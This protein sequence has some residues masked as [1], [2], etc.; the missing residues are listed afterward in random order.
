MA[1][2]DITPI[3]PGDRANFHTIKRA[4]ANGDLAIMRARRRADGEVVTLLCALEQDGETTCPKPLAV[5]VEGNP[6]DLFDDPTD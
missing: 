6:F 2:E 4:A 5:M 3:P 1:D